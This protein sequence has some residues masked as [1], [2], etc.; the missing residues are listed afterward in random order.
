MFIVD[1]K[2]VLKY[3]LKQDSLCGLNFELCFWAYIFEI[4]QDFSNIF[5]IKCGDDI[6]H[7][8]LQP[9]YPLVPT[10]YP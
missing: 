6:R 9:I 8:N 7:E 3:I 2:F 10:L 1:F 4:F 5:T